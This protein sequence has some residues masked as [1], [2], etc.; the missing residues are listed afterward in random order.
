MKLSII[1]VS[2]KVKKDLVQCLDSLYENPPACSFEVIVVD[3]ASSDGTVEAIKRDFPKAIVIANDENRGF[4][5]ANNQG[6]K[7]S[8]G[9]YI[10]LLNPD[11]IVPP[12]SLDVL[13]NFMDEN[14]N[15]GGCGPQLL[16]KDGTIQ[17][18]A[19][20]FPTFRG[21]LYRHTVFRFLRIFRK[22]YKRWLMKDFD[23]DAQKEVDQLMG[24]ALLIRKVV[25]DSIGLM[26]ENFFMY[27]EEVDICYRIKQVG[28]RIVFVPK[29][30]ITHSGG[31][32][33]GQIPVRKRIMML[34]SLLKFF[35]KHRGRFVTAAFNLIFKP[36]V[37]IRDICN[38]ITSAVVYLLA[39]ITMNKARRLRAEAKLTNSTVFVGKYCWKLLFKM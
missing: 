21:A 15:V 24:S 12:N 39:L 33:S 23:Y 38:I 10:L 28:R 27:Y 22:E 17:P 36:S 7:K 6:I 1:I 25:I 19:R 2:W 20:R 16:N 30:V 13:V 9:E 3:N 35:R 14:S 34:T 5:A 32:S 29:A 31:R 11:T 37:I 8:R 26:D 4:A 18:S